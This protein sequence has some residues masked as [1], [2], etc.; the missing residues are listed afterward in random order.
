MARAV[1]VLIPLAVGHSVFGYLAGSEE[2]P[3]AVRQQH[4]GMSGSSAAPYT[5]LKNP[6]RAPDSETLN[7]FLESHAESDAGQQSGLD[8]STLDGA[9]KRALYEKAAIE[10]GRGLYQKNCRPCHGTGHDGVGPMARMLKLKP[11]AFTD[12]GTI[13]T[14]VEDAVFWRVSEGG[15]GLPLNATP[16]DSAMPKWG[17]ELSED[18]RWKIIMAIYD[19]VGIEPRVLE[20]EVE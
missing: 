12:P 2:V 10:E 1:M 5:G 16:W 8:L 11:V 9:G 7:S 6:H 20:M 3:A 19:D 4:P 17:D 13:A 14:L 18:E 15:I